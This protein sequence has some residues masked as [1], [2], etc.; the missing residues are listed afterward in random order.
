MTTQTQPFQ[1]QL[2]AKG[3]LADRLALTLC[4][5]PSPG[6]QTIINLPRLLKRPS[7][8]V[9]VFLRD[10][11]HPDLLPP[12]GNL[13]W[14]GPLP[15]DVAG[16]LDEDLW[17]RIFDGV[18][19]TDPMAKQ[20]TLDV[21]SFP[22]TDITQILHEFVAYTGQVASVDIEQ[23]K[24]AGL[25]PLRAA[26]PMRR[27]K[28]GS[29]KLRSLGA[30]RAEL[31]LAAELEAI[32]HI[33]LRPGP[34]PTEIAEDLRPPELR[35]LSVGAGALD[36]LQG[37]VASG[38]TTAAAVNDAASPDRLRQMGFKLSSLGRMTERLGIAMYGLQSD[39]PTVADAYLDSV[40]LMSPF[41]SRRSAML[42]S[43]PEEY[44]FQNRLAAIGQEF[45]LHPQ[46]GLALDISIPVS[47]DL[48]QALST[49]NAFL[50]AE[51]AG[52]AAHLPWTAVGTTG[53]TRPKRHVPFGGL[54]FSEDGRVRMDQCYLSNMEIPANVAKTTSALLNARN[55]LDPL[56]RGISADT[57]SLHPPSLGTGPLILHAKDRGTS[58]ACEANQG[59][60][61]PP[62][63]ETVPDE[64]FLEDVVIGVRPDLK[65]APASVNGRWRSLL[66][67]RIIYT[68]NAAP[69]QDTEQSLEPSRADGF[70][71]LQRLNYRIDDDKVEKATTSDQLFEWSGW[72][73]A[74]PMPGQRE[75][76][77]SMYFERRILAR[78]GEN[79]RYRYGWRVEV[80][81][82]H[83]VRDGSSIEPPRTRGFEDQRQTVVSG[84]ISCRSALLGRQTVQPEAFQL[85]RYEPL[86]APQILLRAAPPYPWKSQPVEYATRVPLASRERG[87]QLERRIATRFILPGRIAHILELDRHGVFDVPG[88]TPRL[89]AFPDIERGTETPE[90][91][92]PT[93]QIGDRKVP[94]YRRAPPGTTVPPEKNYYPDPLVR[95]LRLV[96]VRRTAAGELLPVRGPAGTLEHRHYLYDEAAWP[97]AT[98]LR[99]DFVSVARHSTRPP[100]V[101]RRNRL[102]IH[103]PAGEDLEL[104]V[105]P[106]GDDSEMALKHALY[107]FAPP[108]SA[109]IC[110]AATIAI[111]NLT[112]KP[113]DC[114][115]TRHTRGPREYGSKAVKLTVDARFDPAT[116]TQLELLA[117]W[118]DPFDSPAMGLPSSLEP[119]PASARSEMVAAV[120]S[121]LARDKADQALSSPQ[122]NSWSRETLVLHTDVTHEFP[123]TRHRVVTYR[124][125]AGA[126]ST[127]DHGTGATVDGT[128]DFVVSWP[129]TLPPTL[130]RV[131][132]ATPAFRFSRTFR[133]QHTESEREVAIRLYL[134]RDWDL[135]SGPGEL[136]G[137][138]CGEAAPGA[139]TSQWGADPLRLSANLKRMYL[140]E[141][142]IVPT[143]HAV[144]LTGVAHQY[145]VQNRLLLYRP[146]FDH[147]EGLW[148][149]DIVVRAP[150]SV[151]Q[152][153][154]RLAV[155]RFQPN[156]LEA[157]MLSAATE[158]D[159]V[160]L[161]SQR[162]A[163][164][165]GNYDG[166]PFRLHVQVQGTRGEGSCESGEP[167]FQAE[168]LTAQ[169]HGHGEGVWQPQQTL[170]LRRVP[171]RDSETEAWAIDFSL[172]REQKLMHIAVRVTERTRLYR[173]YPP[174]P[175]QFHS[176][177][178]GTQETELA[179]MQYG[180]ML[181]L[182]VIEDN[183]PS[184][185]NLP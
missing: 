91:I 13:I 39:A 78:N 164:I 62:P 1:V 142:D 92:F 59:N 68:H 79:P 144:T 4:I 65:C 119:S 122:G 88:I 83:V 56:T 75:A 149:V 81:L 51:I 135:S 112:A 98:A 42:A 113:F 50:G 139:K 154:V 97:L 160:Q 17:R 71:P 54:T 16:R 3:V 184:G 114:G 129:A 41:Q 93:V 171:Q 172:T 53:R 170:E 133:I 163:S 84:G 146:E 150:S 128:A 136:L 126:S 109:L 46:L 66:S 24:L 33:F 158:V 20:R 123:D 47:T 72:N 34:S 12:Q 31:R 45:A 63:N 102:C 162:S 19:T 104:L 155:R 27:F 48:A 23:Q 9:S 7:T 35:S 30:S 138:V 58:I 28:A 111:Q 55:L 95:S 6:Q 73:P 185:P 61:E 22:T 161:P 76:D 176:A 18:V 110:E 64:L 140:E 151:A 89:T 181:V 70:I 168:L 137:V 179:E 82:R 8:R 143:V 2:I 183:G 26:V 145:A 157:A 175:T 127:E 153:F 118:S 67:R 5:V 40:L 99:V 182:K 116:T 148:R 167:V 49:D 178:P 69:L 125:R 29:A 152:P 106:M 134:A 32:D 147:D 85:R 57:A 131:V 120:L 121:K 44:S 77:R 36:L 117:S 180:D 174:R 15:S 10:P 11:Q 107:G 103:V 38:A 90:E 169:P 165:I 156:A 94:V 87:G 108:D 159:F 130:V 124:L 80:S 132:E 166:D 14:R 100:I 21:M 115:V 25:S 141:S 105:L 96:L 173:D 101:S 177:V 52:L 43:D 60:V 37:Y 86:H 74:V